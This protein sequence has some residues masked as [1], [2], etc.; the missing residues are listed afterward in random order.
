MFL[1]PD[2][3]IYECLIVYKP[4]LLQFTL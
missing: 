1:F 4:Q 2:L 3:C